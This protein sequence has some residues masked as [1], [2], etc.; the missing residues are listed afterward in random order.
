[1]STAAIRFLTGFVCLTAVP[2]V[3][4][5]DTLRVASTSLAIYGGF[6]SPFGDWAKSRVK[7]SVSLFA[8]GPTFQADLDVAIGRRWTLALGFGYASLNGGDWEE[9][10]ASRGERLTVSGSAIHFALLLRPHLLLKWPD[11]LR[12]E[13][14]PAL[15]LADGSE[16]YQ[17]RNYAYDFLH[18]TTFGVRGGIEYTRFLTESLGASVNAAIIVFPSGVEY[19]DGQDQ[20]IISLPV[21]LGLR[22]LF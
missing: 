12:I 18:K 15:L 14:G 17:G 19:I 13:L 2:A 4:A 7:P 11:L 16:K 5:Q 10:V 6:A 3:F 20:T 8:M 9:Y 22:F 1:M 21:T